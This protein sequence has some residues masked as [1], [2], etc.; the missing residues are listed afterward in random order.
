MTFSAEE[1]EFFAL[2]D[3]VPCTPNGILVR[4]RQGET[5]N[6][7]R[8]SLAEFRG[9]SQMVFPRLERAKNLTTLIGYQLAREERD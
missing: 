6:V 7:P 1:L 3:D 8:P 2:L 9:R 5:R 4:T